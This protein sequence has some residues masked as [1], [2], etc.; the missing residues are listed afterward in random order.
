[1]RVSTLSFISIITYFIISAAF[2]QTWQ[3]QRHAAMLAYGSGDYDKAIALAENALQKAIDM[4][5][6]ND[7]NF[8]AL[9]GDLGGYLMLKGRLVEAEKHLSNA[10]TASQSLGAVIPPY[11]E[12]N[13]TNTLGE[14][15]YKKADFRRADSVFRKVVEMSRISL[16]PTDP[17]RISAL[18][19][20]AIVNVRMGQYT[21]TEETYLEILD[22]QRMS[23]GD[24][25]PNYAFTLNNLGTF[26]AG[27]NRYAEA[28]TVLSQ[29]ASIQ[30]TR[31]GSS[32]PD[33]AR[34]LSNLG[35]VQ[36]KLGDYAT[37]EKSLL[38][39]LGIRK[40]RLGETH[41]EYLITLNNLASL[42][43]ATNRMT[44][45]SA[46]AQQIANARRRSLGANHPDYAAALYNLAKMEANQN[47]HVQAQQLLNQCSAI[48]LPL[49]PQE[50]N[51][52]LKTLAFL[53]ASY[54]R[55]GATQTADSISNVVST[56]LDNPQNPVIPGL[57]DVFGMF[58][59]MRYRQNRSE[60]ALGF[61]NKA[62][63]LRSKTLGTNNVEYTTLLVNKAISEASLSKMPEASQNLRQALEILAQMSH[64]TFTV[65]SDREKEQ[66]QERVFLANESFLNVIA[67][68]VSPSPDQLSTA[69][70]ARLTIRQMLFNASKESWFTLKNSTDKDLKNLYT[71]WQLRRNILAK[72]YNQ[73]LEQPKRGSASI[74]SLE[75]EV[76][77][78]EKRLIL[79]YEPLA[80]RR[81]Y[82]KA[83]W[84]AIKTKLSKGEVAIEIVRYY[85][86]D[87][88]P[89]GRLTD[90]VRYAA[91]IIKPESQHPELVLLQ[92][93]NDLEGRYLEAYR[94]DLRNQ[95][96]EA[97]AYQ[98]FW[99]PIA[100]KL[101]GVK[102]VYLSADGVYHQ[103][104]LG[105]LRNPATGRD[106]SDELDLR[107]L[108]ST[109]E[110]LA[111]APLPAKGGIALFGFPDYEQATT[112]KL[113]RSETAEKTPR[114]APDTERGHD[115]TPL[116]GT[117][118]EV[119]SV[120]D[121]AAG[122]G[123]PVQVYLATD[124]TEERVKALQSPRVLHL[125]THGYFEAD[126]AQTAA[127]P[128]LRSGLLLAGAKHT[129]DRKDTMILT[130]QA[131]DGVL[132]A[133]EA[134]GLDMD[135]TELVVLS[136]CE[137]GLGEVKNGEGVYGLQRAFA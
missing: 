74:V 29:A 2:A 129:L 54:A 4:S 18:N 105:A 45:A 107:L 5:A 72:L 75:N 125:A 49:Y 16:P 65:L 106:L 56:L 66:L 12:I 96:Y 116:P 89:P 70:N 39:A 120:R 48:L 84:E 64:A 58:A 131:E 78:L 69:Y 27:T 132:T 43:Q 31:L 28:V 82:E 42:Y 88:K 20:F 137:T 102:T 10:M 11:I 32:H 130:N 24:K 17:I 94:N 47:H 53:A 111:P 73:G 55:T 91:L 113:A 77:S 98:W 37:A 136:A 99:Q 118:A 123:L 21:I 30:E 103:I 40:S 86:S 67:K 110:L 81:R 108:N 41:E 85:L 34:S 50:A 19:N 122:K 33:L 97:D 51:T 9:Q 26:Y 76:D 52:Y 63:S 134:S 60:Q 14:V 80:A 90:T 112:P 35:L 127:N 7:T 121:M 124:A 119:E 44:E 3:E 61:W 13:I 95:T 83:N 126:A 92:N 22:L 117:K 133:Y 23:V 57:A 15:Y 62:I 93:G 101:R 114:Y 109:R 135:G 38:K 71:L 1:M 25:H 128:M 36:E 8:I 87:F 46:L 104:A 100:E 59:L 68:T 115:C 79:Q 6:A